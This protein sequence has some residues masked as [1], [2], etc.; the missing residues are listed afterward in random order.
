MTCWVEYRLPGSAKVPDIESGTLTPSGTYELV[1]AYAH[2]MRIEL[3][4]VWK[5]RKIEKE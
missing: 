3:E 1:N 2:R 4:P 5:G